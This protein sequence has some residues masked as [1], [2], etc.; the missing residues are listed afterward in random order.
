VAHNHKVASSNLAP[1]TNSTRHTY[2]FR[3]GKLTDVTAE[4]HKPIFY[5]KIDVRRNWTD[6]HK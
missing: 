3:N 1:A 5:G 6:P 4:K 2:A